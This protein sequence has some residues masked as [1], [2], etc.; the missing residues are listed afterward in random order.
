MNCEFTQKF[1]YGAIPLVI[2][3]NLSYLHQARISSNNQCPDD[4][5]KEILT[6]WFGS[7]CDFD[8]PVEAHT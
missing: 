7:Y 3:W 4:V 2:F 1:V 8:S 6:A 5:E